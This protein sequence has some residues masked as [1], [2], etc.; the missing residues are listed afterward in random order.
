M[1]ARPD[2]DRIASARRL[3]DASGAIVLL[4]GP[5][6]VIAG[7]DGRT[8]L[9]TN[10][11]QRLATAG[12]GDVLDG[13]IGGL[14]AMGIESVRA[15]AAGAWIHA[16]AAAHCAPIGMIAS[17]LIDQIPVVLTALGKP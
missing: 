7:P 10:G 16:A 17:D 11:D 5:T 9:V 3:V 12:T 2:V 14:L 8:F 4:K 13:T 1:G 15:A 6:T